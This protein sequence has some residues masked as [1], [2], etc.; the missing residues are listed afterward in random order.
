MHSLVNVALQSNKGVY[1][2]KGSLSDFRDC[3]MS[4]IAMQII[5]DGNG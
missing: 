4:V 5:L 1:M 3:V 2:E